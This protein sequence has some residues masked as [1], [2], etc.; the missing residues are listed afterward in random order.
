MWLMLQHDEPDDFV[1]A[2]GETHTVR[3]FVELV[4]Q[5]LDLRPEDH[6]RIDARYF[7]PTEV[8][9]LLG[10]GSKALQVLN[11]KPATSFAELASIMVQH[12][13]E[14]AEIELRQAQHAAHSPRNS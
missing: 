8:D 14:L 11:W 4:F 10:D 6:V 9:L 2:T 5:Q 12:D 7:R 1:I 13:L 3:E